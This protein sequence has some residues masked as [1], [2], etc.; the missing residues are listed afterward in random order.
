MK[1]RNRKKKMEGRNLPVRF[2]VVVALLAA[3]GLAYVEIWSRGNTLEGEIKVLE[4]QVADA[5]QRCAQEE[6]KWVQMKAPRNLE[7]AL[8]RHKIAMAY[9]RPD[10]IVH[11]DVTEKRGRELA[12][13]GK[14]GPGYPRREGLV[15]E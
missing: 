7:A 8:A 1:M 3:A 13:A 9:P 10:Q 5:E 12:V 4:K 11:V 6:S 15:R 14:I 2:T